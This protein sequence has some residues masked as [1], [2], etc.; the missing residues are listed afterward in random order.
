MAGKKLILSWEKYVTGCLFTGGAGPPLC[1]AR[2]HLKSA[3]IT[4]AADSGLLLARELGVVP[5]Y[6]VGDMDSLPPSLLE[7]YSRSTI[8]R[9]PRDKDHTDT[10][11]GIR[12][13]REKG[14]TRVILAGGG[15][16][17]LDH[18]LAVYSLFHREDPPDLWLTDREE[19]VHIDSRYEIRNWKNREVSLL[20][21]G[22]ETAEM[23]SHGLKW[24]LSG[25]RWKAGDIGISNVV[26]EDIAWIKMQ[27]GR[28]L[29]I[30][31]WSDS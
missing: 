20:P 10:E 26:T 4:A 18:L 25:L 5:D 1:R 2:E 29:L 31:S 21:L 15:G 14:C 19:A 16:G 9:Y 24:P 13:L 7:E 6:I 28:L 3:R 30:R 27:R 11:L 23:E 17:R 12:L 22:E 8:V